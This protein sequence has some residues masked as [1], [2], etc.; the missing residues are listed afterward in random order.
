MIF[1][2]RRLFVILNL[3]IINLVCQTIIFIRLA[4]LRQAIALFLVYVESKYNQIIFGFFEDG[5]LP[6]RQKIQWTTATIDQ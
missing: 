5:W 3:D 2:L 4:W 6:F 1:C